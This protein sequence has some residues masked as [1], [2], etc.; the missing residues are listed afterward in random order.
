MSDVCIL[1]I[2]AE[3][4]L[5]SQD[6]NLITLAQKDNKGIVILINKW[7]LIEKDQHTAKVY[8]EEMY[9]KIAPATYIPIVFISATEKQRIHKAIDMAIEVAEN[10][11]RK[12]NNL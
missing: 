7:D 9:K 11:T 8:E 6:L 12:N 4:G 5:E 3:R 1:M 10:R 2:D